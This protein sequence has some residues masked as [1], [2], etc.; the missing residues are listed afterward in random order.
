MIQLFVASLAE[1]VSPDDVIVNLVNPG[2]CTGTSLGRE[3]SHPW[4][5]NLFGIAFR[6]TTTDGAAV[7][8]D[9]AVV[10]GKE[11][12]GSYVSDGMIKP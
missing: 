4:L 2:F 8:I 11:S 1:Q 10:Q 3:S 12:H 9:A 7:Y 5:A 6:R